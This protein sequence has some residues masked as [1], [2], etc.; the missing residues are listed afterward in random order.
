VSDLSYRTGPTMSAKPKHITPATPEPEAAAVWV[1]LADLKPWA[2]NP[3]KN[4]AAIQPV[5]E[6]IRRFGFGAPILARRADGEIIAGHTRL[7]A[8]VELGLDRVP[9][10]Y[11]D[12]DPADAH[13]LALADNRLGEIAE[14]DDAQ[15]LALLG[16]LRQQDSEAAAVAGWSDG[17][18]DSLLKAA[19]D[20]LLRD[21]DGERAVIEDDAPVDRADELREKWQTARG[22]M[23]QAGEHRILCGDSTKAEDVARVM[24][25]DVAVVMHTDPPYGVD[26]CGG[27]H[28]PR[29][30]KNY[31][32]GGRVAND[33]LDDAALT[34]LLHAAL[35]NA[36]KH[37]APGAAFYVWHPP[38]RAALFLETVRRVLAP[39][40]Q[41][42]IWS[43]QNFVFG[44][45]DYHW[46]HE[47]CLYGWLPGAAHTWLGSRNQSTVW[48]APPVGA[49][50]EKKLHPTAKPL[51]LAARAIQNH[52]R[53]GE[54]VI[55]PF[56][57]SGSTL[58][59]AEQTGRAC[60]AIELEPKYVAVALERL[61]AMGLEP[62][63]T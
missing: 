49:D 61:S 42:V 59:A 43:K 11:L 26:V 25:S 3:R 23:W 2:Q 53:D 35:T 39:H 17:E 63:L 41:I 18:I 58:V 7:A 22:Q 51:F 20:E 5:L 1:P 46:Q 52:A 14:W 13:L 50:L 24:G 57:G 32:S 47:P 27:T 21:A 44:R 56:S 48:T 33:A 34:E 55:E 15:L 62:R 36:A 28:D 45:Q 10:R 54:V 31:G 37:M 19:G 8:A 38:T 6:S 9:V 12:L 60:R 40:R 16:D 30:E 4:A 29:D